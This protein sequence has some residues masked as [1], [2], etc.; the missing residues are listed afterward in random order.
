[1]KIGYARVSTK[2]QNLELQLG[3]LQKFECEKIYKEKLSAIKDRPEL[4]SMVSNLREGD[5]VVVWKLDRLGRSLKHLAPFSHENCQCYL[6]ITFWVIC[7]FEEPKV[8][9]TF[10]IVL[11]IN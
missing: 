5:I 9:I 8:Y 10:E 3:A 7:Y 6:P 2:D 4:N 11:L 1:M